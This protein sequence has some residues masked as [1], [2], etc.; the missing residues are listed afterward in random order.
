MQ[1]LNFGEI[2]RKLRLAKKLKLKDL[3]KQ[4]ELTQSLLS[5]I[6]NNR[7]MP[8]IATLRRIGRVLNCS[9][10]SFFSNEHP[11][12]KILVKKAERKSYYIPESKMRFEILSSD[13][14]GK[15][16]ET[17][18]ITMGRKSSTGELTWHHGEE[19]TLV[20]RGRV[21]FQI[22]GEEYIL[23]EG[24]SIYYKATMP[25]RLENIGEDEAVMFYA[26]CPPNF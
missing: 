8:S 17:A 1:D 14:K 6:E 20:V 2:I 7:A 12:E 26:A 9:L 18:L 25:H 22:N 23:D 10:S 4:T 21:R 5:Q 13:L 11:R 15:K 3:A 24:D 19:M 16:M